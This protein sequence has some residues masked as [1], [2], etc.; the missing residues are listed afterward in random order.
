MIIVGAILSRETIVKALDTIEFGIHG[1][2]LGTVCSNKSDK[3]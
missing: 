3:V 2:M 1:M